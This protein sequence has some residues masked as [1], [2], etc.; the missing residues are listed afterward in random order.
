[1]LY[2]LILSE[3]YKFK[4]FGNVFEGAEN[5]VRINTISAAC[6]CVFSC[7]Q[8]TISDATCAD[9]ASTHGDAINGQISRLYIIAAEEA[10]H[11][12]EV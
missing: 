11:H 8:E 1:M 9:T 10:C 6:C 7:Y 4:Y 3:A 2:L 5:D 12:I